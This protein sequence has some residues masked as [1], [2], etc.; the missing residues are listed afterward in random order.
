MRSRLTS[1][2]LG[3]ALVAPVG[4]SSLSGGNEVGNGGDVVTCRSDGKLTSIELLDFYEARV[5]TGKVPSLEGD[6]ELAIVREALQRLK[7]VDPKR[8]ER[9][10]RL[11]ERFNDDTQFM[12]NKKLT[13]VPD[14]QHLFMPAQKGCQVEQIAILDK[15]IIGGK[16]FIISK[17]LWDELPVGHRAGLILHELVYEYFADLGERNSIRARKYNVFLFGT[18]TEAEY[19]KFVKDLRVRIYR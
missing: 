18:Y 12:A 6:N 14:S 19:W 5:R 7:P 13:D 9:F 8:A 2:F 16:R 10:L 11:L 17:D 4:A 1:L 3:L 15:G